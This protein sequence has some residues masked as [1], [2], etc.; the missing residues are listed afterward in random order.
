MS[1]KTFKEIGTDSK[2]QMEELRKE[3]KENMDMMRTEIDD[4]KKEMK[5]VK[6]NL[7]RLNIKEK[8]KALHIETQR[9][10]ELYGWFKDTYLI[11]YKGV[12]IGASIGVLVKSVF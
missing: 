7:D 5:E 12:I 8:E 9:L 3:L 11:P 10:Y 6:H 4:M 2:D 1:Y